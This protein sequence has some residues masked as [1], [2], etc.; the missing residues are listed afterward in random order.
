MIASDIEFHFLR[1]RFWAAHDKTAPVTSITLFGS[2]SKPQIGHAALAWHFGHVQGGCVAR[3]AFRYETG[4]LGS[5]NQA[6]VGDWH[7]APYISLCS[8]MPKYAK[9]VSIT[10]G[11]EKLTQ[12]LPRVI[13]LPSQPGEITRI[14]ECWQSP[15]RIDLVVRNGPI[16]PALALPKTRKP[17]QPIPIR[18]RGTAHEDGP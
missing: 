7:C 9:V 5:E 18:Q 1:P 2:E 3:V 16:M 12:R 6:W 8:G 4:A 17:V 13:K 10:T 15:M 14:I 11:R